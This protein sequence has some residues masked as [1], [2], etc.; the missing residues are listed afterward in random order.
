MLDIKWIR[1][2]ADA[3]DAGLA[4]RGLP[5]DAARLLELDQAR[6]DALTAAQEIQARRNA[7][8]IWQI[9]FQLKSPIRT[10]LSEVATQ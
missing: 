7:L 1:E 8:W 5:A 10:H 3:F 6:R 2:N 4:R 9:A